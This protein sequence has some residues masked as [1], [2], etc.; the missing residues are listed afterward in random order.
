[1]TLLQCTLLA[2]A[3]VAA[4]PALLLLDTAEQAIL[5]WDR[6]KQHASFAVA[7]AS[8]QHPQQQQQQAVVGGQRT[9][10]PLLPLWPPVLPIIGAVA[11]L[12]LLLLPQCRQACMTPALL[13]GG[14]LLLQA[15]LN[16][17][18][19]VLTRVAGRTATAA[20]P[21]WAAS[22]TTNTTAAAAAAAPLGA[23]AA[24]DADRLPAQASWLAAA[25]VKLFAWLQVAGD[26]LRLVCCTWIALLAVQATIVQAVS[27]PDYAVILL[28]VLQS[29]FQVTD[30]AHMVAAASA[31]AV[32]FQQLVQAWWGAACVVAVCCGSAAVYGLSALARC[33][34]G[35]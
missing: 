17:Q 30:L 19:A 8:N 5:G 12:G 29:C 22:P 33:N 6:L 9:A 3:A 20:L 2:A 11:P 24:G 4:A 14:S 27:E 18:L 10:R 21:A 32:A 7:Q 25:A 13:L 26:W 16:L 23:A 35:R 15:Y 34:V 1:M 31:A 28:G